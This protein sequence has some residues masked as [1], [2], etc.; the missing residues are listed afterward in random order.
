MVKTLNFQCRGGV[1]LI[2]DQ[3]TKIPHAV[4][5]NQ[6]KKKKTQ[7]LQAEMLAFGLEKMSSREQRGISVGQRRACD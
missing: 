6:K 4:W 1:G 7:S 2:P 3:G 5:H